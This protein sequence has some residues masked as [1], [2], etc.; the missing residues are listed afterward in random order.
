[1]NLTN[2]FQYQPLE[3]K[4]SLLNPFHTLT[5]CFFQPPSNNVVSSSARTPFEIFIS[6]CIT[7]YLFHTVLPFIYFTL[8]YRLF[9]SHCITIYL[10]H[11]VLPFIYFTLY[12]HLFISHCTTVYLSL[13]A[14]HDASPFKDK[15]QTA[16][17]ED[18]V[19]TAL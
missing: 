18:P 17:F 12:Y 8:Y 10:F 13:H 16:L 9:I 3:S 19:R 2:T 1:M 5:S 15:A 11:T 7:V 4:L 6:H 14:T